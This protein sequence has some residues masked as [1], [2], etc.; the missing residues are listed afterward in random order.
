MSVAFNWKAIKK[1]GSEINQFEGGV[2]TPYYLVEQNIDKLSKFQ[3]IGDGCVFEVDINKGKILKNGILVKDNCKGSL[4][5]I[6]RVVQTFNT[7][8]T[9]GSRMIKFV[10]GLGNDTITIDERGNVV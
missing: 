6:R 5:N 8:T 1:D 10:I 2:E 7:G 3:L 4:K 9:S